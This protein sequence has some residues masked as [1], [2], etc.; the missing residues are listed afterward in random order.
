MSELN[1]RRGLSTDLFIDG[2]LNPNIVLEEDCWYLCTDTAELFLSVFDKDD[3]GQELLTL[4]QINYSN[5]DGID[6]ADYYSKEEIDTIINNIEHPANPTKVSE[7][8][9]DANYATEQHVEAAVAGL[10]PKVEQVQ[11]KL[12]KEVI[13]TVE[14]QILP[15][16]QKVETEIIPTVQELTEKAATQEWVASQK[17]L[18]NKYEVLPV[19]GMFVSYNNSEV[20]VN[21]E[22]V[23][24]NALPPQNAGDGSS[25]SYYYMTFRAYA[26]ENATSVIEGSNDKMDA[27]HSALATD[28]LGRKYTT[29][30][31]AI[32][33]KS[34]DSWSKFGDRSTIDK[35][36]GFYYNFHW[37]ADD[38]LISKDK[39][40]VILTN[41]TCH[42]DLVPDAVARRIDERIS[43]VA[44]IDHKHDDLYDIKGT[45]QAI[46]DELLNGA[47]EAYDTLKELGS[48]IDNNKDAI[49]ALTT[50]ATGKADV[51]HEH[52]E[53]AV[54]EHSHANY[55]TT[56]HL[57]EDYANKVHGHEEYATIDHAHNEYITE[58]T[59]DKKGY[60]TEHQSL[61][62][63]AKK[64]ELFSRDYNDLN[65]KPEIPSTEGL[66]TEEFV[67]TAINNIELPEAE[68]YKVDFNA[69]DYA[70][71]VEAYNNGKVLV[72]VNA[73]PDVNSYA[74]M[75]YV[76]EKY[77]TFTKFLMSRSETYGA[78][79]TYYLSPA[80]TWEVSKEVKLNKVEIT[81]DN[82]LNVGKQEL[83][84]A[85]KEFVTQKIA[86]AELA[87][88]DVDLSA[89]YTKSEV[90]V[91]I[92]AVPTKVSEL[93]NDAKYATEEYVDNAISNIEYP[94]K[95][96]E[97]ENDA[98]Y[99]TAKDIP[100]VNLSNYYNKSETEA[101]VNEVINGIDIP[102]TS[103]F[104]T[105]EDV[106]AKGYLTEHQNLSEYAKKSEI[107][108]I[109]GLA[110]EDFVRSEIAKAELNGGE[111]TEE[112]L[113]N[114]L[115]NYYNKTEVDNKFKELEIPSIEG[116]ATEEFVN[117]A[118]AGIEIPETELFVVDFAAP[119]FTAAIN[120]YNNGKFL[121]LA[122]AAPDVNGYAVMNYVRSDMI[123]FTKFLTSR[124]EAYGSFNTY[125]LHSD[126]TW[127][128][129]KEVKLNKVEA[130]ADGEVNGELT[131]IRI[132]KEVYSLP[133]TDGLA[134][135]QYVNEQIFALEIPEVPT[136]VSAFTN[137]AGY[138]TEHQDLSEYV[139]KTELPV[140]DGFAT[141]EELNNAI[142]AIEHPVV[143]L[144]NYVTKDE[145]EGF[146]S[147]VP[148]EYIT[149][150]ELES[151]GYLTQHQ[152]ISHLAT[153]KEIP[154]VSNFALK[155]DIPDVSKFISEIPSEYI[156][157][158]EL[159][160]KGYL[161]EHQSL[162]DYSTTSEI[163]NAIATA[164]DVKANDTPFTTAKFISNPIGDFKVGDN[165]KDLKIA[166]IL[167]KL[168]GLTDEQPGQ[169]P[170]N[171]D[172]PEGI[173]DN[174]IANELPMYQIAAGGQ[175]E[176][177]AFN[178]KTMTVEESTKAPDTAGF[179]QVIDGDTVNES[180]YQQ[181]TS[182]ENEL[183]YMIAL[184]NSLDL[185][186]DKLQVS[187]KIWDNG[188]KEWKNTSPDF[189]SQLT[190]DKDL[191]SET[192]ESCGLDVPTVPNDYTL[193]VNLDSVN[194]G[195]KYRYIIKEVI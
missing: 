57:H 18:Q 110:S 125:Y 10:T 11:T 51:D 88:Q 83:D 170:E 13:P 181:F 150:G 69:P 14:Q 160:A 136:N 172:E 47:G 123:T 146:I 128:I 162:E 174:L 3:S 163:A 165:I 80:N 25:D 138:L 20:R 147:E 109:E 114:L 132:G 52:T 177:V 23:D 133:N 63:Y 79:N 100:E 99:I 105:M 71:A 35:Y 85:T 126:N 60:L 53:Y 90:D 92:P 127:E 95:V 194:N 155:S 67:N 106:E 62:A 75:N 2:E 50:I 26:P 149:E 187:V 154:D 189:A 121:V 103:S 140:V 91:L 15:T 42:N 37:Y 44:D 40:R 164:V 139:K 158:E 59:L 45:A 17:Y 34:G 27:E 31:S 190:C 6:L 84:V 61:E 143:N 93:E 21:T 22:H 131:S 48:L 54:V 32:A 185:N 28:S 182:Y 101:L 33:N 39:V 118:I 178:Y 159:T 171:P 134:S 186:S 119:D 29:I 166:E 176:E 113:D 173:I 70:E 94:T 145:I 115:A 141:K 168:L 82:K 191:I 169:E 41:D 5:S 117:N 111:V 152:D 148:A 98:G 153:K 16:V 86:E 66:A 102:D 156:T 56:D 68:L 179:Y 49:E 142:E 129:S 167:A 130:N 55:A 180:G 30:W 192:L 19:D 87:D 144:D 161:T 188:S 120:A 112:E 96:S 38:K 36:L 8:E 108:S 81:E 12:E 183:F 7:L 4:K 1:I 58:D 116:L 74:V 97:L 137:D 193:W 64:D 151:K 195:E 122:N 65:N 104:I 135:E 72:L 124:S 46:K 175:L 76:S 24:I 77:I 43:T 184:P 157:E 9:N 89:Y 78:F 107:P 73:A